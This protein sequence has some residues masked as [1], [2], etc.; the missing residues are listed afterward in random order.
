MA[1]GKDHSTVSR[2]ASGDAGIK[3]DDLQAFLGALSL[4]VVDADQVCVNRAVFES[5][6][7]LAGA[8]IAAPATLDWNEPE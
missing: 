6:K 5:Y 7:V 4:K 8:A 1:I 3:L 2:I